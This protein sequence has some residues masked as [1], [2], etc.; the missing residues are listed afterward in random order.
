MAGVI[1]GA[2]EGREDARVE[3]AGDD[4]EVEEGTGDVADAEDVV[5]GLALDL[6]REPDLVS[7]EGLLT[8]DGVGR[9]RDLREV[10]PV[11][12]LLIHVLEGTPAGADAPLVNDPDLVKVL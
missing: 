1:G 4:D 9:G 10:P 6:E 2:A 12:V 3:E 11:N 5:V 7:V 8:E